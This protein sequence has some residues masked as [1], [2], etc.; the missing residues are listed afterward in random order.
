MSQLTPEQKVE[1]KKLL[2]QHEGLRYKPYKDIYGNTTIGIGR[3]LSGKGVDPSEVDLMYQ[4]DVD[5]FYSELC[6]FDWYLKLNEARQ[7][8]LIDMAFMGWQKFLEF[9]KM[10]EYLEEEKYDHA[11][12]EILSSD[13]AKEVGHRATDLANIIHTGKFS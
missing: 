12:L 1:L 6:Q 7:I 9:E 4:N 3:N 8:A 5:Y 2:I 11:A 10:I 13:Y